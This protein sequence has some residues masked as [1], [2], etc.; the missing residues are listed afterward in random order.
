MSKSKI[1]LTLIT[2]FI[3][4]LMAV[5]AQE[6][7]AKLSLPLLVDGDV[8]ED[9]LSD[10]AQTRL[11]VFN[12]NEGDVVTISMTQLVEELDP[13][14]VLLGPAGQVIASDDD[15]GEEFLSALI[16][17]A[18]LPMTGSYFIVASS[19][20]YID[21]IIE[22]ETEAEELA[23]ELLVSGMSE[24]EGM[25]SDFNFLGGTLVDGETLVGASTE[26]EPVF[27]YTF[28]ANEGDV[29]SIEMSSDDFDTIL[30]IFA[31]GGVR[32]G[33][34]DDGNDGTNSAIEELELPE[35][36][37]YMVFATDLFFY[38]AGVEE[39]IF[40]GGEFEIRLS[41]DAASGK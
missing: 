10:D 8:V 37:L 22:S 9:F 4:S 19:F 21:S 31:P 34:N 38:T 16:E 5:Q 27:F 41:Q 23:Y 33:V 18:E 6:D 17:D 7:E 3:F 35:D 26:E 24:V 1:L 32:I 39:G 11:Y 40:A 12:A 36:G 15:S 25:E 13:F 28:A 30:H 2:L 20:Y 29:V 14:L